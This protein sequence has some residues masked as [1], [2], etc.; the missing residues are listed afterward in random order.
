MSIVRRS[1]GSPFGEQQDSSRWNPEGNPPWIPIPIVNRRSSMKGPNNNINTSR[2]RD[3]ENQLTS[4][5]TIRFGANE[6]SNSFN[7]YDPPEHIHYPR[8]THDTKSELPKMVRS[9]TQSDLQ[10]NNPFIS[11]SSLPSTVRE[12][13]T[14][15]PTLNEYLKHISTN[16]K[17]ET[18]RRNDAF[19][20][21]EYFPSGGRRMKRTRRRKTWPASFSRKKRKGTKRKGTKRKGTK[22]KTR[23]LHR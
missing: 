1:T 8:V 23:R 4:G 18:E 21:G 5:K 12:V 20:K 14:S 9:P 22:R 19:S 2:T 6:R 3:V 13:D 7:V 10:D 11:I 16:D 17:N 15:S